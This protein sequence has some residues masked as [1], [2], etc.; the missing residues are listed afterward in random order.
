MSLLTLNITGVQTDPETHGCRRYLDWNSL[1]IFFSLLLQTDCTGRASANC[2]TLLPLKHLWQW[3]QSFRAKNCFELICIFSGTMNRRIGRDSSLHHNAWSFELK[4]K[5]NSS[6]PQRSRLWD[7]DFN[8]VLFNLL[9][10]SRHYLEIWV[11]VFNSF[12]LW[13]C[14]AEQC[15][16]RHQCDIFSEHSEYIQKRTLF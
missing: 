4:T 14:T 10:I 12:L 16:I 15:D 5:G 6:P 2:F 7:M 8:I 11:C 1:H 3:N 9:V 13:N